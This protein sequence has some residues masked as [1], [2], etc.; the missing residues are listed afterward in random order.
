MATILSFTPRRRPRPAASR[1][2]GK[3]A[4]VV[5]FPGVRYE[6]GKQADRPAAGPGGA[7]LPAKL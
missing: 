3:P 2:S 7:P 4:T 5:I 6:R 1:P